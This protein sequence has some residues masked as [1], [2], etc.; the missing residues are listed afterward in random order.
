M[1]KLT[2]ILLAVLALGSVALGQDPSALAPPKE[3]AALDW[4]LGKWSGTHSF[5]EPG[6]KASKS[7]AVIVFDKYLGKRFVRGTFSGTISGMKMEGVHLTTF[8]PQS[9]SWKGWWFDSFESGVMEVDGTLKNGVLTQ[10]SKPID[11]PGQGPQTFRSTYSRVDARHLK[12]R[13]EVKSGEGW[14]TMMEG[15]YTKK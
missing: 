10:I 8:D 5:V 11:M 9:K 3:M 1:N 12:F 2:L 13:L 7:K 6:G 14:T 4:I 15:A